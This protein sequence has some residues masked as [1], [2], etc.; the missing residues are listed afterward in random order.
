MLLGDMG[1]CVA[2]ISLKVVKLQL[3]AYHQECLHLVHE[4]R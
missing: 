1:S 4:L 2:I 3:S